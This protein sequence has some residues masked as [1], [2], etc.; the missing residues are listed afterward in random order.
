MN[1]STRLSLRIRGGVS[2]PSICDFHSNSEFSATRL[3]TLFCCLE[4]ILCFNKQLLPVVSST[5][6]LITRLERTPPEVMGHF[7]DYPK[8]TSSMV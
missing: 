5:T 2:L 3:Y 7:S 6:L 8:E 4:F 1:N